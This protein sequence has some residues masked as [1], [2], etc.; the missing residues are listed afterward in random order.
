MEKNQAQADYFLEQET[1]PS[2]HER[3]QEDL[4]PRICFVRP[5]PSQ[6]IFFPPVKNRIL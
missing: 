2:V 5:Y 6:I 3:D 4:H 1:L